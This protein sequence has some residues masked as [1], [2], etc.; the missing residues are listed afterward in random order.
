MLILLDDK[1]DLYFE[2]LI[3]NFEGLVLGL[4]ELVLGFE[5]LN[6]VRRWLW[7]LGLKAHLGRWIEV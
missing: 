3:L 2:K 1:L 4:D 5:G 6:E 7:E